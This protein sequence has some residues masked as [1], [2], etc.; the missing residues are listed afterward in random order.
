MDT[1]DYWF[2]LEVRSLNLKKCIKCY[3]VKYIRLMCRV[4]NMEQPKKQKVN[5]KSA[6]FTCISIKK[7][8]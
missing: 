7:W 4:L 8:F 5:E 3:L 2:Y 1:L 6:G